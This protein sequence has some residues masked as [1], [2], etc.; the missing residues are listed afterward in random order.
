MILFAS[1]FGSALLVF[2]YAW[3]KKRLDF[4]EEPK[5]RMFQ[6]DE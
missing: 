5:Y 4:D 2:L 6:E 1:L 3:W